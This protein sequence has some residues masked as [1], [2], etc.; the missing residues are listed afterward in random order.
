MR[1]PSGYRTQGAYFQMFYFLTLAQALGVNIYISLSIP[2]VCEECGTGHPWV[3]P[4]LAG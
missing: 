1:V 4:S 2:T 3:A